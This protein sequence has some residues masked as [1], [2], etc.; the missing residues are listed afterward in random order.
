MEKKSPERR[1][2]IGSVFQD[3][4]EIH[5]TDAAADVDRRKQP[6]TAPSE[7]EVVT[8]ARTTPNCKIMDHRRQQADELPRLRWHGQTSTPAARSA[9]ACATTTASSTHVQFEQWLQA[10]LLHH[11]VDRV[12]S[13]SPSRNLIERLWADP[14]RTVLANVVQNPR[15]A[16]RGLRQGCRQGQRDDYRMGLRGSLR[17]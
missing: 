8:A 1:M 10:I 13:Y 12:V 2:S 3:E 5:G 11:G 9:S 16:S 14:E 4:V 6:T 17:R 7:R 15:R